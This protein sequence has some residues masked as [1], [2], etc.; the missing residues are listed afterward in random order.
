MVYSTRAGVRV[1]PA[2][3]KKKLEARKML[4]NTAPPTTPASA[5]LAGV[6]RNIPKFVLDTLWGVF[7]Q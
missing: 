5:Y 3:E 1:D 2:W 7:C 6:R 4:E